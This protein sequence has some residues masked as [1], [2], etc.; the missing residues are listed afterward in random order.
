MA[1]D[2]SPHPNPSNIMVLC[3]AC[4]QFDL[5]SFAASPDDTKSNSAAAIQRSAEA[6][7]EF[8]S[9]IYENASKSLQGVEAQYRANCWIRLCI[10]GIGTSSRHPQYNRL[11]ITAGESKFHA[12][13]EEGYA[14]RNI[15]SDAKHEVCIAADPGTY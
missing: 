8:C 1:E 9:F 2:K 7:C 15:W 11:W 10:A 3:A 14:A 12:H 6:G 5:A 4:Q 13:W